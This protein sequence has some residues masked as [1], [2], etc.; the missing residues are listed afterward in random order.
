MD[1]LDIRRETRD[2]F[3][4][5]LSLNNLGNI[6][7]DLGD[8]EEAKSRLEEAVAIQREIGSKF[9]IANA[10]NNLGNVVREQGDYERAR[11]LYVESLQMN[12][13]LGAKWAITYLF[14]DIGCLEVLTGQPVR[15]LRLAGAASVLREQIRSPL[16]PNEQ[17]KLDKVLQAA[18]ESLS[19]AEQ[20]AAW[21]E[22]RQMPL[23][24]AVAFALEE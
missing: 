2:R 18:R 20:A 14:E 22:G 5:A 1:V 8:Y 4:L 10:L 9:F 11:R 23:E 16:P 7:L 3:G 13:E 6:G 24:Q 17:A 12:R 21:T 19:D 15:A